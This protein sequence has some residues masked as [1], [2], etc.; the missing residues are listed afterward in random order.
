MSRQAADQKEKKRS[1]AGKS[2][3][4][5]DGKIASC[6]PAG[7]VNARNLS[8]D[9]WFN[10]P[11]QLAGNL[12]RG[13]KLKIQNF[14][15]AF[16]KKRA[17]RVAREGANVKSSECIDFTRESGSRYDPVNLSRVF[18]F[19]RVRSRNVLGFVTSYL[20]TC[21]EAVRKIRK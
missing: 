18:Q 5:N 2:E 6:W 17:S 11:R 14:S 21:S 13:K 20:R 3:R 8:W 7:M 1:W 19:H 10:L 4:K 15:R 16:Q 9:P 12:P